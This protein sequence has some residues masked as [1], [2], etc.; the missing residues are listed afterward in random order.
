MLPQL[1]GLTNHR[2]L[3]PGGLEKTI[4]MAILTL[5]AAW[6][7]YTR[8]RRSAQLFRWQFK[9]SRLLWGSAVMSLLG[10]FFYYQ[11]SLL[12]PE[13]GTQWSGIITV[14]AFF[15]TLLTLGMA[16]AL[17]MHLY[18]PSWPTLFILVFDLM[19]YMDRIIIRGRRTD[20]VELGLMLLM[21]LWFRRRWLPPRW[22]IV[23]M[24]IIGTLVINSIGDYRR[25]ALAGT[26]STWSGAGI[27]EFLEIDYLGNLRRLMSGE[28]ANPELSN[29]IMNIE[30]VDRHMSLDL[31]LSHWNALI[32][33]YVPGQFIGADRK[34]ALIIDFARMGTRAAAEFGYAGKTGTT[35][36]GLSDSFQSF[37]YFGAIKFFII[38]LIMSRWYGAAMRGNF[39]AQMIMM[40]TLPG[41]LVGI[42]HSTDAFFLQFVPLVAFLVP[43]LVLARTK[44][45]LQPAPWSPKLMANS[46]TA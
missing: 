5:A 30:A 37:W 46:P 26:A 39:V 22:L 2:F 38:G 13:A 33:R 44:Q 4:A 36:T 1:I 27:S 12:R 41:S 6:W 23:A 40:L 35:P 34:E 32:T 42:T 25:T 10:A 15:S 28:A 45:R 8:N 21:V 24:L 7:G 16:I 14:Y 43:L 19:F 31:G 29:A 18:K 9:H 20:A 3:P 11:T 17:I